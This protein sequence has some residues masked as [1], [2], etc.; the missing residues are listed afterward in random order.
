MTQTIRETINQL[1]NSL[2]EYIEAT[3]HI[4]A[5][6]LII[7]RNP[8]S[9]HRQFE[10]K[11]FRFVERDIAISDQPR[12]STGRVGQ[13]GFGEG[14]L[15]GG[16]PSEG[17]AY[18]SETLTSFMNAFEPRVLAIHDEFRRK[19]FTDRDLEIEYA[20]PANRYSIRVIAERIAALAARLPS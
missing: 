10:T 20:R 2:R 7:Q 8:F 17:K 6:A 11:R 13:G 4:S 15:G 12:N 16:K 3:Y 14:P 9:S 18:D 19:G 5:P 1:H